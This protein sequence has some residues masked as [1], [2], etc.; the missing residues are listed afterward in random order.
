MDATAL[1][2][3]TRRFRWIAL[4]VAVASL[5]AIVSYVALHG[6]SAFGSLAVAASTVFVTKL[7]IFGGNIEDLRF[8]PWELG[9]IA[10]VI[11]LWVSCALLAGLASFERLPFA[12][13]ALADAN[14]R[15]G[16]TLLEYPGLRRLAFWGIT[17]LVFLPIPGSGAVTGTLVARMVG[18]SRVASFS[19][20]AAGAAFAVLTYAAVAVF[21]GNQWERLLTDPLVLAASVLVLVAFVAFA[22]LRVRRA[23][24]RG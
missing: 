9:L 15:A 17:V 18:L 5:A 7:S 16:K 2:R 22:W 12:G 3:D 11:D 21:L 13:K 24:Q 8:N 1:D 10:W 6:W 4:A 23:L 14:A 20:V 19:A